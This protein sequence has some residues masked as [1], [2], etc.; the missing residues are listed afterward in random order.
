MA[1]THC[2]NQLRAVI[3][4]TTACFKPQTFLFSQVQRSEVEGQGASRQ[5]SPEVPLSDLLSSYGLF[6]GH[7]QKVRPLISL[8]L[9]IRT[10]MLLNW[11]PTFMTFRDL[12][13]KTVSFNILIWEGG[14]DTVQ[15]LIA[16]EW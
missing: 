1:K 6:S 15:S 10:L 13:L 2:I 9:L 7:L 16:L 12:F 8:P 5:V 3:T 4:N 14:G 11:G